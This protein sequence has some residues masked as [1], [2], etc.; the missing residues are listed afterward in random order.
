MHHNSIQTKPQLW[1]Y[2]QQCLKNELN[3]VIYIWSFQ[4][5]RSV[6][7]K[8]NSWNF[9]CLT[10]ICEKWCITSILFETLHI[11]IIILPSFIWS[12]YSRIF[13][14]RWCPIEYRFL[15]KHLSMQWTFQQIQH[16][17]LICWSTE[18]WHGKVIF[19]YNQIGFRPVYSITGD[20]TTGNWTA[21]CNKKK[22]I[23]YSK[24]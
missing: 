13:P 14:I 1:F 23:S 15:F 4:I 7:A 8:Q 16:P 19:E 22:I 9:I 5:W 24:C 20:H 3:F 21:F 11:V 6:L 2:W 17:K 12:Y 18:W 10:L